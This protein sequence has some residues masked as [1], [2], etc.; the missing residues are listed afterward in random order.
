MYRS[1]TTHGDS[2]QRFEAGRFFLYESTYR[3]GTTL[4]QHY[5]DFAALMFATR[6]SFAETVGR[7]TFECG[8]FEAIARPG[9]EAHSNRYDGDT[10][11]VVVNVV[12]EVFPALGGASRLFD[13]PSVLPPSRAVPIVHRVAR[14]LASRDEVSPLVVE[15]LLLELIGESARPR[16]GG[17][18]RWLRDAREYI[19]A[20][21]PDRPSLADIAD[22][23]GV[24][25][26]SLV[27]GFRAHLRCSPGEYMRRLRLDHARAALL[28]TARPIAEI[29]IDAGFYDQSHFTNAF[30]K[31][32][33]MTPAQ[34]RASS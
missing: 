30:R 3:P 19:H 9:G 33:G 13:A 12:P 4:P 20:H 11:C 5:H 25:P 28:E 1:P 34:V 18:P 21:W 14:E 7:R 27:R 29:A 23:G 22:A 31:R 26:A 8:P 16:R 17:A 15:G 24:H 6:G 10:H 32:F 2:V